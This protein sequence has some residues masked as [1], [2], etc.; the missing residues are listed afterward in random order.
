MGFPWAIAAASGS[1]ALNVWGQRQANE[2]NIKLAREQREFEERMAN[3]AFQ[4]QK[5]DLIAAGFNPALAAERLGGAPM[6]NTPAA[7]VESE[8]SKVDLA[9]TAMQVM[10]GIAQ[11]RNTEANTALQKAQAREATV[12]ANLA[13]GTFRSEIDK[14]INRNVEEYEWDNLATEVRRLEKDMTA[15]QL[16]KF[17]KITPSIIAMA[18]Q[19]AAAGKIDLD[20]MQ[21]IANIGGVEATK[22]KAFIQ[23]LIETF[24]KARMPGK[25]GGF[26]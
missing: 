17:R 18:E 24:F 12:N 16:N 22:M 2:T 11:I 10:G 8:T 3:T 15:E 21:N 7:R 6:V 26:R 9:G 25:M 14:R 13:E 1:T 19:S 23:L 20:A 5:A 4:R